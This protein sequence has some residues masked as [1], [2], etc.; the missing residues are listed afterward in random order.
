MLLLRDEYDVCLRGVI[1]IVRCE[2]MSLS[3]VLVVLPALVLV[4]AAEILFQPL[5]AI[6]IV[7]LA[8]IR[9]LQHLQGNYQLFN[10]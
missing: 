1:M 2:M 4:A 3:N 6:L 8:Q 7:F 9:I 10:E 5:L